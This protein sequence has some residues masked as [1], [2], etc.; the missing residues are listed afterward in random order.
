MPSQLEAQHPLKNSG[1][2]NNAN[3]DRTPS[4]DLNLTNQVIG[5]MGPNANPRLASIFPNL[6]KH[7]HAFVRESEVTSLELM[8]AFDLVR[9]PQGHARST[10]D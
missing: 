8:A 7:L 1:Y 9:F 6:I 3:G 2:T 5:A 4:F 10:Q